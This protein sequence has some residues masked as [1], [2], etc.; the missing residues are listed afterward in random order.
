[1]NLRK[2]P[3]FYAYLTKYALLK[4][5]EFSQQFGFKKSEGFLDICLNHKTLQAFPL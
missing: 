1:M 3:H 5:T 4:Y 2:P